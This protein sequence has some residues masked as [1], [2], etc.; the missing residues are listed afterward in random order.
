MMRL[1]DLF[2]L[3]AETI[4]EAEGPNGE[5]QEE[6]FFYIDLVRERAGLP[7]VKEAWDKYSDTPGKY[8][9]QN[10]MRQIIHRERLI[11][12]SFEGQ[13]FWDLR[14]WK[15]A[16]AEYGKG[17]YGFK[18]TGSK[19]E[20][21]YQKILITDQKFALKDYFWPIRIST[22]EQNPN[23]IQNIGW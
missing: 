9:T 17:I 14:R 16:P 8:N 6:M 10:G 4:N 3:Y 23:L 2:L 1:S 15:E 22:I 18:V 5:H 12:L 19:A 21:Y 20:D 11:E 13:R 7:S